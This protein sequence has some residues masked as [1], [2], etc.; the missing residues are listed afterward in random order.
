MGGCCSSGAA[1]SLLDKSERRDG[2]FQIQ[3]NQA[4]QLS[5]G[6]TLRVV[7]ELS[8]RNTYVLPHLEL[9]YS[10]GGSSVIHRAQLRFKGRILPERGD[11]CLITWRDYFITVGWEDAVGPTVLLRVLHASAHLVAQMRPHAFTVAHGVALVSPDHSFVVIR[12]HKLQVYSALIDDAAQPFGSG[13]SGSI[14]HHKDG[15]SN[16]NGHHNIAGYV[17]PF[18][19]YITWPFTFVK[20]LTLLRPMVWGSGTDGFMLES[21]VDPRITWSAL[22]QAVPESSGL[23]AEAAALGLIMLYLE[24][25]MIVECDTKFSLKLGDTALVR[26]EHL[27][28]G[29]ESMTLTLHPHKWSITGEGST[30]A[31]Q[32]CDCYVKT[33][34]TV[35]ILP[36]QLFQD[37]GNIKLVSICFYIMIKYNT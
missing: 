27:V 2:F 5:D 23:L 18:H 37:E 17:L 9:R 24:G 28:L 34:D 21:M 31:F 14:V 15:T 26:S 3:F 4:I 36:V 11:L 10:Q 35:H 20:S 19:G 22:C 13:P 33:R 29:G 8:T 1:P 32:L 30:G 25:S 6:I 7:R 12:E 16:G